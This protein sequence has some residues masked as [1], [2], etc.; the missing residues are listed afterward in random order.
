[1][2]KLIGGAAIIGAFVGA[3]TVE[4][5]NSYRPDLIKSIEDKAKSTVHTFLNA[6]RNG[7]RDGY[8]DEKEIN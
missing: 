7:F 4:I 3:M 1:M 8:S 5:I 2:L 6:F